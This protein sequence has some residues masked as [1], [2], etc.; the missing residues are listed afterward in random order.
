M[1]MRKYENV[2]QTRNYEKKNSTWWLKSKERAC[3]SV[4][5]PMWGWWWVGEFWGFMFGWKWKFKKIKKGK[6]NLS[7]SAHIENF[8]GGQNTQRVN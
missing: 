2:S 7:S 5:W 4:C 8:K 3:I 6:S 1:K